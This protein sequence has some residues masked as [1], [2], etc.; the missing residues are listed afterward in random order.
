MQM[1][2]EV[3]E[4]A[5]DHGF[6][7]SA[8]FTEDCRLPVSVIEGVQEIQNPL[9]RVFAIGVHDKNGVIAAS[10]LKVGKSDGDRPLMA[11]V[12]AQAEHTN[13]PKRRKCMEIVGCA[14][15]QGA[16]IHD[17]NVHRGVA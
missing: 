13:G 16:I 8:P 6:G 14:P 1:A 12:A 9:R 2:V 4:D 5:K 10:F 3:I 15:G 11:E 17:E 7:A